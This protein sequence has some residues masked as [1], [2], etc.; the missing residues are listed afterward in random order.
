MQ[1]S[2][3]SQTPVSP[4]TGGAKHSIRRQMLAIGLISAAAVMAVGAGGLWQV[5]QFSTALDSLV[6]VSSGVRNHLEAD[7]MHDALR[8]DVY[9]AFVAQSDEERAQVQAELA[10]HAQILRRRVQANQNLALETKV[11][12]AASEVHIVLERY[13]TTAEEVAKAAILDHEAAIGRLPDLDKAFGE[14]EGRMSA[15]SDAIEASA[16]SIKDRSGDR[17]VAGA[18]TVLVTASIALGATLVFAF[19]L[20]RR[21]A[22]RVGVAVAAAERMADGHFDSVL[23]TGTDDEVGRLFQAMGRMQSELF[24]RLVGERN[25]ADRVRR[26]LETASASVM[27]A[28]ENNEIFFV[29][30]AARSLM[31]DVEDDIRASIPRFSAASL[32]GSSIDGFWRQAHIEDTALE[33]LARTCSS[34]AKLGGRTFRLTFSPVIDEHGER[35]GTVVEWADRTAELVTEQEVQSVVEAAKSGDLSLRIEMHGKDGFFASLGG[36]LNDLLDVS[37]SVVEDMARVFSALAKGDLSQTID[38]GYEGAYGRLKADAN[39]TVSRLT[40]VIGNIKDGAGQISL[41][42]TEI[43]KG[44]T[45]LSQRTEQQAASL[46][47]TASSMKEITDIV[48]RNAGNASEANEVSASTREQAERGGEVVKRAVVAMQEINTSSQRIADIIGVINEI[49]F[50]T[51]LLA[52]NAAVESARA[53]EQGRGFAVVAA[54]VRNLAQRSATAAK[55]IKQLIEDSVDKVASGT[56]LVDESGATL[57]QIVESVRKVSDI[58]SEIA[59]ASQE[60]SRGLEH[61]NNAIGQMDSATQQNAALV[62]EVAVS[63]ESMAEQAARMHEMVLFFKAGTHPAGDG[64][65]D[66]PAPPRRERRGASRPWSANTAATAP[67]DEWKE[68]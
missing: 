24:T 45:D 22:R 50:Q 37:A 9:R 8:G 11:K 33:Q 66:V 64:A 10:E 17:V 30:Q 19:L 20:S 55:E 47:E 56:Q 65:T 46:Q 67:D 53:G 21:L 26:A 18:V 35:T 43:S 25:D 34:H 29:N 68:F 57:K 39:A 12:D 42:T 2:S 48:Q 14:L 59:D 7:M 40:E 28:N 38:A 23:S 15:V 60:Q 27:I 61:V 54:E 5:A 36:A 6:T 16:T 51:N 41:G 3:A 52:L 4:A 58:V 1:M 31:H 44:N 32:V 62:Q 49:A 13:V 63:S